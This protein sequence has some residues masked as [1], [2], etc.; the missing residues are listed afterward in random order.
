MRVLVTGAT[1]FIGR[2]LVPQ[3][4]AANVEIVSLA[5]DDGAEMQSTFTTES[6]SNLDIDVIQVDLRQSDA[7]SKAVTLVSPKKVV[8]LAAAGVANPEI[9]PDIALDHNVH[10]T[11]NLISACFQNKDLETPPQQF[12]TIRTPGESKPSNGYV[13]SKAAAWSF[14]QMFA[15]RYGWP[16]VGAMIFQAYG[17]GQPS[18]TFVQ[19]ALRSALAGQDFVMTSGVQSRDWIFLNDVTDGL[20]AILDKDLQPGK[21]VEL[22]TGRGTTLLDVAE[23]AYQLV[24]HGG[25]PLIGALPDRTGEDIEVVADVARTGELLGWRPQITLEQGLQLLLED[26]SGRAQ[27][28]TAGGGRLS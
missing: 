28:K 26:I 10:G 19:A 27:R 21:S 14:C 9:E 22:G 5:F 7:T 23:L 6:A 1:G 18:H 11:L 24:G 20:V 3:L 4:L 25:R 15:R 13:A 8:H 2:R 12:I 16:I 17:P